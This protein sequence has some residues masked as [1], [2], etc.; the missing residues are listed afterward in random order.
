MSLTDQIPSLDAP[1]QLHL[2]TFLTLR[3]GEPIRVL[4]DCGFG[5]DHRTERGVPVE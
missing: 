1:A 3:E 4:C 5:R 2:E